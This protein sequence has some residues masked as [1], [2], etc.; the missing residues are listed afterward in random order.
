[1]YVSVC[2]CKHYRLT[3]PCPVGQ[4][5][6]NTVCVCVCPCIPPQPIIATNILTVVNVVFIA[7]LVIYTTTPSTVIIVA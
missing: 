7:V 5:N 6:V 1:M 2:V 3:T 4:V